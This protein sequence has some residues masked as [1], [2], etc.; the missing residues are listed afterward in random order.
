MANAR[1]I[2]E[3]FKFLF[4]FASPPILVGDS[5]GFLPS[6]RS[7]RICASELSFGGCIPRLFSSPHRKRLLVRLEV[8]NPGEIEIDKGTL[9]TILR[10]VDDGFNIRIIGGRKDVDYLQQVK[11]KKHA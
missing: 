9:R 1:V 7:L 10:L 11:E 5:P 4:E 2:H 6:L 8:I 3:L